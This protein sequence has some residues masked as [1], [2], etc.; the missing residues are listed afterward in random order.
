VAASLPSSVPRS[1]FDRFVARKRAEL[2]A[3]F[4]ALLEHLS[5]A[6]AR[7]PIPS[8][9]DI[10]APADLRLKSQRMKANLAAVQL[11]VQK[12]PG[13]FTAAE[14]KVLRGYSGNGGLSIEQV[15]D[16]YPPELQPETFGLIHEFFTPPPLAE[17]IGDMVC[18]LLPGLV[19]R[20]GYIRALEPS[21]GIGR[22]VQSLSARRCLALQGSG[23][24]KGLQWT[25]VEFSR[26]SS[27]LLRAIRPDTTHFEMLSNGGSIRS[28]RAFAASST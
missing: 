9:Q 24:I 27:R 4:G 21:A 5:R 19:G 20:D 13:E 26:V 8:A 11:V 28:R 14:L 7:P 22:L 15:R 6:H 3:K 10:D 18:R 16:Q 2:E 12:R 23:Q 17:Q 1:Y 25:T